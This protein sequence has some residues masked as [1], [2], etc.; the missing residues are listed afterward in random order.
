LVG[1]FDAL[2]FFVEDFLALFFLEDFVEDFFA[3]PDADSRCASHAAVRE[4][5]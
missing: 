1:G 4:R 3:V 2:F 5:M